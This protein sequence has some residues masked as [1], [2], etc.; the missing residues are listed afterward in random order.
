MNIA[1][2]PKAWEEILPLAIQIPVAPAIP[3]NALLVL[4][5]FK[6]V[7]LTEDL[8]YTRL[9]EAGKIR[10]KGSYQP[11]RAIKAWQPTLAADSTIT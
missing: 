10:V 6:L 8:L 11:R 7:E 1:A 3:R 5:K 9:M 4:E 2:S